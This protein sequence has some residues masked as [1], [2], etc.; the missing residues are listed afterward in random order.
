MKSTLSL[1]EYQQLAQLTDLRNQSDKSLAFP[2]LGLFGEAGS[3]LSAVK[4]KQR[5]KTTYIGYQKSVLEEFGDFLWYLTAIATRANISLAYIGTNLEF[6]IDGWRSEARSELTFTDL[7]PSSRSLSEEP[8]PAFEHTL[9]LLAAEV[10]LLVTDYQAGRLEKNQA[11]LTGRLVAILRILRDAALEAGIT[12]QHAAQANL[13]KIFDRWPTERHYP[14]LFDD[15]FPSREQIPR[16]LRVEIN[17]V[18]TEGKAR[19]VLRC[20]G[21]ALG[22]PLTDNRL[23]DDDYRFH[24]VFHLAY[25]AILGWSPTIRRLLRVK[26]KSVPVVDEAEDGA[27]AVLIEEGIATW[28]F[29]HAQRLNYFENIST[30]DYGLLK[31]VR[32]FVEGYEAERCPLWL[33][34]EAIL[35]GYRVFRDIRTH[36]SGVIT[37]DLDK[38]K[39][40]VERQL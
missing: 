31:S 30:L 32:E 18:V 1:L 16:H 27:R 17:E 36:R 15:Q 8:T 7:Q 3:L 37:I 33:W 4:K 2:L 29:N 9:L 5:D 14:S 10:G 35:E 20:D 12:L 21:R 34:E 40:R 25:A 38:R 11:A 6:P 19:V 23:Q 24:D 22:D 28:I 26:R 39:I 13:D